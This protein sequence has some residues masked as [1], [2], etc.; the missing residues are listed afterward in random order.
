MPITYHTLTNFNTLLR[1]FIRGV[2]DNGPQPYVASDPTITYGYGYT[3]LRK[4]D[5]AT[6]IGAYWQPAA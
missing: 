5:V 2:E 1:E 6:V 4:N 3:F